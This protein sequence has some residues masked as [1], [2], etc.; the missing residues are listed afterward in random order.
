MLSL[1]SLQSYTMNELENEEIIKYLCQTQ[2]QPLLFLSTLYC[3]SKP[4][5]YGMKKK[6]YF[7]GNEIKYHLPQMT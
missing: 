6:M 5:Q 4:I 7:K 3:W 1:K 2:C